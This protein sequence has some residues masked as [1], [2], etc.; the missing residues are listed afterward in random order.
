MISVTGDRNFK[1]FFSTSKFGKETADV[2][3]SFDI[4][5]NWNN[6]TNCYADGV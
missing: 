2:H 3:S 5:G 6:D 4:A 1:I